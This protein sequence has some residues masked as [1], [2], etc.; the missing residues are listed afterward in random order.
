MCP[1]LQHHIV[2]PWY[3]QSWVNSGFMPVSRQ[4]LWF[5][6]PVSKAKV[7][8]IHF[9]ISLLSPIFGLVFNQNCSTFKISSAPLSMICISTFFP[10]DSLFWLPLWSHNFHSLDS[11]SFFFI[12]L[13]TLLAFFP[14]IACLD[15][16]LGCLFS[17]IILL[18][19]TLRTPV[20]SSAD[21]LFC[22]CTC[23]AMTSHSA[24]NFG[25]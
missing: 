12:S 14:A 15:F 23:Q 19:G 7:T 6:S 20:L 16:I 11:C 24:D 9:G 25:S 2:H 8:S 10:A 13:L 22:F 4:I 21:C 1:K 3:L 17:L 5:P 18:S